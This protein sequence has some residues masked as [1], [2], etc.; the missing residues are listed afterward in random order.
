MWK[1]QLIINFFPSFFL[2]WKF[3]DFPCIQFIAICFTSFLHFFAFNHFYS[4]S[5]SRLLLVDEWNRFLCCAEKWIANLFKLF[6]LQ[7]F[8]TASRV[9]TFFFACH[10]KNKQFFP[11]KLFPWKLKMKLKWLF[12]WHLLLTSLIKFSFLRSSN[13]KRKKESWSETVDGILK[14]MCHSV[15]QLL[16]INW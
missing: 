11:I 6:S 13:I 15:W 12:R 10:M 8:S 16:S 1:I 3:S 5:L 4:I 2:K 14:K 7:F 9:K